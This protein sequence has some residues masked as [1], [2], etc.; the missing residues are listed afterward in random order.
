MDGLFLFSGAEAPER[1]CPKQRESGVF[2]FSLVSLQCVLSMS[3]KREARVLRSQ[4]AG[5]TFPLLA[6]L[7]QELL[8]SE[9]TSRASPSPPSRKHPTV[10]L[11]RIT[12]NSNSD[13]PAVMTFAKKIQAAHCP[14]ARMLFSFTVLSVRK[15]PKAPLAQQLPWN[16]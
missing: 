10:A 4:P 13:K 6:H 5:C 16:L 14:G 11:V 15:K 1:P 3:L 9:K 7:H 12:S 8:R 2:E